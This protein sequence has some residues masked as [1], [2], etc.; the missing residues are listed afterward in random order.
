M[1]D[2]R[3]RA[4]PEWQVEM[5]E[6]LLLAGRPDE[7]LPYILVAEEQLDSLRQTGARRKLAATL[8]DLKRRAQEAIQAGAAAQASP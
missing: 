5:A 2:Q 1:L 3:L 8:P 7:A 4:T 6:L